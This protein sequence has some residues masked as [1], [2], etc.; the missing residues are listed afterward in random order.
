MATDALRLGDLENAGNR[1]PL[2]EVYSYVNRGIR[3]VYAEMVTAADQPYFKTEVFIT[4]TPPNP[5]NSV[6]T[7]PLP[8]DFFRLLYVGWAPTVTQPAGPWIPLDPAQE[9][10]FIR[11]TNAGY[12]GGFTPLRYI[13]AAN[14]PAFTQGTIPVTN[15]IA[16]LP[17]P[18]NASVLRIGYVPDCPELV[19]TTDTFAGFLGFED[20]ATTWAAILM[21]RKDDLDTTELERDMALHMNRIRSVAKRRDGSRPPRTSIVRTQ[22]SY[23]TRGNRW[24]GGSWGGV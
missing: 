11:L 10:D 13:M 17:T 16:I 3:Y 14:P 7:Y 19:N 21:R 20:A 9:S 1:F 18:T 5:I 12:Y 6:A 15:S 8:N 24:G 2:T 23:N 22:Y 4:C